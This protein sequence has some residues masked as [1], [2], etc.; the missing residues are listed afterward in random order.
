M[1]AAKRLLKK[2]TGKIGIPPGSL[3]H[4]GEKRPGTPR[5]SAICY[6]P[7]TLEEIE[8]T[9][10]SRLPGIAARNGVVWLNLDGLHQVDLV[11]EIGR[12]CGLHPL[13]LE[14]ILNSDHRPKLEIHDDFLFLVIKE[15]SWD[16]VRQEAVTEQ[17][18][19]II[20]PGRVLSFQE[21]PGDFFDGVRNTLR[22]S[23]GR[24]R[25]MSADYL[26]YALLD[27][28]IDQ[29]FV[30]LEKLGDHIEA[31]EEALLQRPNRNQLQQL[32]HLKREL[33][34]LRRAVWPLRE[35][36]SG[37]QREETVMA[38]AT[39]PFLRDLYDHSVQVLDTV[40]TFRDIVTGMLDLYL[41]SVSNRLN[42][43]MKVLT[44]MSSIFIPLTFLVGVYGM[45]F[46]HMPELHWRW[47]YFALWGVML[48]S[49]GGMG[50][51]FRRKQWL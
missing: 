31:L 38:A 30:V 14:D 3:V 46:D 50:L 44:V 25:R 49:V 24:I 20:S 28:T 10:L 23:K 1:A 9:A 42:E 36:I 13:V 15:L 5:L 26:A 19:F 18:S 43:I 48:V 16:E 6:T 8:I 51:F 40:E 45:N 37:L 22:G 12:V 33:I 41:S 47:G 27:A 2:R 7:E 35:V 32:H 21:R 29:Y 4:V 17:L 11:E 34:L 39:Q